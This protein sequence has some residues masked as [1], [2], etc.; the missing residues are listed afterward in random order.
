LQTAL[1]LEPCV[2]VVKRTILDRGGR[3]ARLARAG[4]ATARRLVAAAESQR[5]TIGVVRA[6]LQQRGILPSFLPVDALDARARRLL[7]RARLV[8][9]VGGDG[10]LLT[11]SHYI[12]DGLALAVNSAPADSVGHFCLTDGSGF[13]ARLDALE[14]GRLRPLS[15]S[16]LSATLD[17]RLLPELA[18]NDVLVAHEHPAMTSRYQLASGATQE[19]HRS[20]GLWIATA[21]GSTAGIRSAGGRPMPLRSPRL[22]YRVRELYREP[23]RRYRLEGGFVALGH[24]LAVDSKMEAG[25]LF[26]DGARTAYRFPF[27]AHLEV[28]SSGRSLRLLADSSRWDSR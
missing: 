18:T 24:A 23:G 8:I 16:R 6:A 27:G 11:A 15:L 22:Q 26:I 5:Q 4:H 21:A 3:A 25:W 14:E 2:V 12:E 7:R 10:T 19:E 17:G 20:S 9:T 1:D 28:R 13:E